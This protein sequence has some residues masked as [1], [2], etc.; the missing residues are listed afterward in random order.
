MMGS[1]PLWSRP[2]A[3]QLVGPLEYECLSVLWRRGAASVGQVRTDLNRRRIDRDE[4]AYTT[5]MTI[6]VRLHEKG[7]L[8][9]AKQGRGYVYVPIM[10]EEQLVEQLGRQ[11]IESLLSRYGSVAVAQFASAMRDLSPQHLADLR[12]LIETDVEDND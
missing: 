11:E 7:I 12:R 3:E 9:R 4:L 10:S 1:G 8:D 6:L 2:T 5:V